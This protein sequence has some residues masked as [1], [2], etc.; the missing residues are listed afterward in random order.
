MNSIEAQEIIGK[1]RKVDWYYNYSD[2]YSVWKRGEA[3]MSEIKHFA[4]SR[5]WSADDI[6]TLKL[7]VNNLANLQMFKT[8]ERKQEFTAAWIEKIDYLFKVKES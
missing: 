4:K 8:E 2:D 1:I 3:S 5:E 7:E 6:A